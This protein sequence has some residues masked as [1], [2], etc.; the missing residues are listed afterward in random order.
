[1]HAVQVRALLLR[2]IDS[3]QYEQRQP[4]PEIVLRQAISIV[5]AQLEL[6]QIDQRPSTV[7]SFHDQGNSPTLRAN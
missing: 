4:Y 7:A 2:S 5:Q 3:M 6:P 1:V